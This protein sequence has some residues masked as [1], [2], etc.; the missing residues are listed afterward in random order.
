MKV[1]TRIAPTP[2]GFIHLGNLLSFSLT[3]AM[4]RETG[5][6]ILLRIDD[7]DKQ[8][9]NSAFVEDI[10]ETLGY[11][12]IPFTA[13]AASQ[14]ER[15][16]FYNEALSKLAGTDKVF[17]CI[18]SR[19]QLAVGTCSCFE[20]NFPLD[21]QGVSWRVNTE[22]AGLPDEMKN[23]IVRKKDGY[24]SYQLASLV[25]DMHFGISLI[26]RGADLWPSTLAQLFLAKL[27]VFSDFLSCKFYHHRLLLTASGRKLSKSGGAGSLKAMR[28]KGIAASGIYQQMEQALK[29]GAPIRS[30]KDLMPFIAQLEISYFRYLSNQE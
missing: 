5:A 30:W 11:F 8:R 24:P 9:V 1:R 26:V 10:Y 23:F 17:A 2:S 20:K 16:T 18:C 7:L 29:V 6:D 21:R 13:T 19:S 28:S 27:L 4:A 14:H 15:L 3:A 25:D 22:G 12:Q